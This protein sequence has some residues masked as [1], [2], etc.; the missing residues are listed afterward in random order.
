MLTRKRH[1]KIEEDRTAFVH[2]LM[3]PLLPPSPQPRG[4]LSHLAAIAAALKRFS[5]T[6]ALLIT[7]S[8]R[9]SVGGRTVRRRG[10]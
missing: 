3:L 2:C 9:E 4:P 10:D 5:E 8:F 6:R 1:A 7:R